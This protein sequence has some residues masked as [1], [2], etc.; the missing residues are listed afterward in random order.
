MQGTH[1]ICSVN[2][3][4]HFFLNGVIKVK[5]HFWPASC[6]RAPWRVG[7]FIKMLSSRNS[8][9]ICTQ[10]S[11]EQHRPART[12]QVQ[13]WQHEGCT[14]LRE[15]WF[16]PHLPSLPFVLHPEQTQGL[17][18]ELKFNLEIPEKSKLSTVR[19]IQPPGQCLCWL[20]TARWSCE[21]C[22]WCRTG[23]FWQLKPADT[24]CDCYSTWVG[25]LRRCFLFPVKSWGDS[26]RIKLWS[27]KV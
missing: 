4:K 22:S 3:A 9:D 14:N 21:M 16:V 2:R 12:G 7:A 6:D 15:R 24:S 5:L 25:Q 8:S 17:K 26:K 19:N 20:G 23:H 10:V 11:P 27:I 18:P 13:Y 1:L